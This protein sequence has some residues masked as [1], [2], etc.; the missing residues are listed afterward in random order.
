MVRTYETGR[1]KEVR[2]K[3]VLRILE[4]QDRGRGQNDLEG[5]GR[6]LGW[7]KTSCCFCISGTLSGRW[8]ALH[9]SA[10]GLA[11]TLVR[12]L[13]RGGKRKEEGRSKKNTRVRY[14]C[15]RW[16]ETEDRVTGTSCTVSDEP[17]L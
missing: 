13:D 4:H 3:G 17:R 16:S 1:V 5:G 15:Q 9:V 6:A 7:V 14:T 8:Q 12:V 10:S 11:A 2:T